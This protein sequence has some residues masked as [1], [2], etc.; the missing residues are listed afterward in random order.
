MTAMSATTQALPMFMETADR[1]QQASELDGAVLVRLGPFSIQDRGTMEERFRTSLRAAFARRDVPIATDSSRLADVVMQ[2][3]KACETHGFRH[4]VV[5]VESLSP[6]VNARG[7]L[8]GEDS[9]LLR[10][11]FLLQQRGE[12]EM[13]LDPEDRDVEVFGPPVALGSLVPR[14]SDFAPP[15]SEVVPVAVPSAPATPA[16]IEKL[17]LEA[18][19]HTA[20]VLEAPVM[21]LPEP[22]L[23]S[24]PRTL[25]PPALPLVPESPETSSDLEALCDDDSEDEDSFEE[26]APELPTPETRSKE[27]RVMLRDPLSELDLEE[28]MK[29]ETS[30]FQAPQKATVPWRPWAEQLEAARGPQSLMTLEKLFVEAYMPLGEAIGDGLRDTRALKAYERFGTTFSHV[31]TEAF[32]AFAARG[33][34]P[35]MVMDMPEFATTLARQNNVRHVSLMWCD[36]MRYDVGVHVKKALLA[37]PNKLLSESVLW[38]AL[39]TVTPRQVETFVR[40]RDALSA[41]YEPV[42]E[43]S[44]GRDRTVDVVRRVRVGSRELYKFD[45]I[46]ARLL[47]GITHP[48]ELAE[49]LVSALGTF[50]AGQNRVQ[51]APSILCIFGDH[52]Y[53]LRGTTVVEGGALPEQVLVPAQAW[54]LGPV[55]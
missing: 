32:P 17:E 27:P 2:A 18:P 39:P 54:L 40:G 1:E 38:S 48:E 41:E 43:A 44:I 15:A 35:K 6:L 53:A 52:G 13:V 5:F 37:G 20:S 11:L 10:D 28:P 55:H 36:A 33:K 24:R 8:D 30:L 29:V 19:E 26:E 25:E 42:S 14:P 46:A 34:R 47:R 50:L 23:E 31:Y 21:A 7:T 16:E 4:L 9:R 3:R 45:G 51:N 49:S 12:V 22:V